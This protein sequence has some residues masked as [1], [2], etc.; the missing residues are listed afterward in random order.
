MQNRYIPSINEGKTGCLA[1]NNLKGKTIYGFGDSIIAGYHMNIGMLHHVV[2]KNEMKFTNYAINGATIIPDIAKKIPDRILVW[3][4]A[5][6][7]ENASDSVPDVICFDGLTND[8]FEIVKDH[9]LGKLTD[10]YQGGYDS[11]TFIGAFENICYQFRKKYQNSQIFYVAVH[12]MPLES[13]ETQCCLQ[14]WSKIVCKKWS[15][16]VIDIFENGG[17]NTCIEGMRYEFSYDG[18]NETKNGNG[19]HLNAEGYSRWYAPLI[20]AKLKKH[21]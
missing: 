5:K 20:D 3:D 8:A 14:Y 12:H 17:I 9:Y 6:Q 16:P 7:I 2:E 4:I 15:I 19:V 18:E 11:T 1:M 10:T 13:E 21:L